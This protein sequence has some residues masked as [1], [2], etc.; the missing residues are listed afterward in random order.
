MANRR[1]PG[2]LPGA[3]RGVDAPGPCNVG[4]GDCLITR[5]CHTLR[6]NNGNCLGLCGEAAG[7]SKLIQ[8]V[9]E[10][11]AVTPQYTKSQCPSPHAVQIA[12][13]Y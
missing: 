13:V 11:H 5:Q 3:L 10:T 12:S 2:P 6:D 9:Y 7:M 4:Q 8:I 1:P